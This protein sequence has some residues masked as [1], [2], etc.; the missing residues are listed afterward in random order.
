MVMLA[1]PLRNVYSHPEHLLLEV[2]FVVT[3]SASEEK[4][5]GAVG[6]TL[7]HK[8]TCLNCSIINMQTHLGGTPKE[9]DNYFYIFSVHGL[10]GIYIVTLVMCCKGLFMPVSSAL[11]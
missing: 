9:N 7:K 11:L 1:V 8:N 10:S 2:L 5:A 3:E 6:L 4:E